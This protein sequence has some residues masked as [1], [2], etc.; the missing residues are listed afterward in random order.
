MI[1]LYIKTKFCFWAELCF[2]LCLF[3]YFKN[4]FLEL[5]KKYTCDRI[6]LYFI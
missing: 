2:F 3:F 4:I 1:L 6:Y 5:D